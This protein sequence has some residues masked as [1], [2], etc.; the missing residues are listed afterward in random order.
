MGAALA[1]NTGEAGAMHRVVCFAVLRHSGKPASTG[2][3]ARLRN[4]FSVRQRSPKGWVISYRAS[5]ALVNP[6]FWR[7]CSANS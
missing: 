7:W 1:A 2:G 5:A 6:V 3:A 4:Q